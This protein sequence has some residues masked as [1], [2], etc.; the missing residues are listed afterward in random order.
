MRPPL[1]AATAYVRLT[2]RMAWAF[3]SMVDTADLGNR[4]GAVSW[5]REGKKGR[6]EEEEGRGRREEEKGVA[7]AAVVAATVGK[8]EE[9]RRSG[10]KRKRKERRKEEREQHLYSLHEE[11]EEKEGR[12]GATPLFLARGN[13]GGAV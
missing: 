1:D 10:R 2:K 5:G 4:G 6:R 12:K 9:E 8:E 13:R 3:G 7:A 11:T